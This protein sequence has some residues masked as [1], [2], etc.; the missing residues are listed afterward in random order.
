M[1]GNGQ[2][3]P[4]YFTVREVRPGSP[5]EKAGLKVGDVI[6]EVNGIDARARGALFP[7]VGVKQVIRIRRG[8][9]EREVILVPGPL[10]SGQGVR[11]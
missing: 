2:F 9:E 7:V 3:Q 11:P 10:P 5:A 4:G 1:T 8:T 6:L